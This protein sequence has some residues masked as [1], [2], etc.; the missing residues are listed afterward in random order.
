[1]SDTVLDARGITKAFGGRAVLRGIDLALRAGEVHALLGENGAG[2]STLMRILTGNER[3]DAGSMLLRG[4]AHAPRSAREARAAG[5][6]FVPQE[7]TLCPDL[8]VA[9]N[10]VLG[11]EPT[12]FGLVDAAASRRIAK[13]ALDLVTGDAGRIDPDVKVA[14]L[15]VAALQLVEIARALVQAGVAGG[16]AASL[17][18]RVLVLDEPT[19]SLGREDATRL[20]AR[21]E[22]LR[23][24]GLAVLLVTHFLADVRAHAGAYTVLRDGV[25][26]DSGDPRVAEERHIVEAM[27]GRELASALAERAAPAERSGA[28]LLRAEGIRTA[29]GGPASLVVHRGE[30]LGIAGLVGSG[31]TEL[32][33]VLAGLDRAREGTVVT[34][35][36]RGVGLLSEDRGG[37][38]LMLA[39]SIAENVALSPRGPF[40]VRGEDERRTAERW[41]AELAVRTDGPAQLVRELSGGNQQKVQFARLL[42]E[43]VDV[44]LIDEPTR[45]VD[46]GSKAQILGIVRSLAEAG[47]GVVV[48]SSQLD[49]LVAV[50]D[51]VAVMKRGALAEA[52]PASSYTEAT[53]ALEVAT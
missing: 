33:R 18:G 23:A 3:H 44:L 53:L 36:P 1:M 19:A 6:A 28:P 47:K 2:K 27:L 34:E 10:L 22:E 50:C 48:V 16:A 4:E 15:G 45:G 31:R 8:T 9:E 40:V 11:D 24:R 42:R 37:E 5:V 30:V 25:V 35:A 52:K 41:I 7:R 49:E 46:V 12:R 29:K 21:V 43:D 20:F 13:A 14:Q 39:R 32:L 38:G 17:K 51:R 26:K